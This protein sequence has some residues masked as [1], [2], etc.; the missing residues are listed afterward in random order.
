[1]SRILITTSSFDLDHSQPLH[2]L[3]RAGVE[4]QMNPHGRRL[5]EAEVA[6]LLNDERVVGMI[7]GVE[8][9]TGS[10]LAGAR[11]LKVISRCGIGLD[12][13]DLDAAARRGIRVYNTPDAPVSAVAE[14]T[15]ALVL[16]LLRQIGVADRSIRQGEWKP[17]MGSLLGFKTLGVLGF[18]RIGRRVAELAHAFGARILFHDTEAVAVPAYAEAVALDVLLQ[19]SDVLTLH[20][21]L[22]PGSRRCIGREQIALMKPGAYL[23]NAA[24]GGLVDETALLEALQSGRLAGAALDTFE[25]EPYRG[26]LASLPQVLL[27]AHMGSYA[28][29]ARSLMER[30]AASNLVNGLVECGLIDA[31]ITRS[32][33]GEAR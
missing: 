13:V 5:A 3:A 21:P 32:H 25:D 15:L 9:L 17:L 7:A 31:A 29:E 14:L 22:A 8:P 27:T 28:R 1:M 4:V 6:A 18:G 23:V 16:G 30:E 20:V 2:E 33:A 19:R 11:G 26:P 12:S 24:R 10:V